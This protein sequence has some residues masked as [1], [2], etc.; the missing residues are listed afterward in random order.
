[1]RGRWRQY[2]TLNIGGKLAVVMAAGRLVATKIKLRIVG[3]PVICRSLGARWHRML[4]RGWEEPA[5]NVPS[6]DLLDG[7]SSTNVDFGPQLA[8]ASSTHIIALPKFL[9]FLSERGS[10]HCF[11]EVEY[12]GL[13][14]TVTLGRKPLNSSK[15]QPFWR[16][17]LAVQD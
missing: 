10:V 2:V 14:G 17:Q 8:A 9:P 3:L 1:M 16:S 15:F 12:Y 6:P 5:L 7:S 4:G 11:W 13:I